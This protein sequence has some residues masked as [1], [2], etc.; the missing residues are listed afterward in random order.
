MGNAKPGLTGGAVKIERC[1]RA[2]EEVARLRE[3]V[4]AW[5]KTKP[6]CESGA[7][8][9]PRWV[10]PSGLWCACAACVLA[11]EVR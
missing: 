4:A 11:L 9:A 5:S 8:V 10:V 6:M 2:Q 3:L 7:H 1:D